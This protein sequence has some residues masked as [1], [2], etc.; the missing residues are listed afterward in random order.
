MIAYLDVIVADKAL[1]TLKRHRAALSQLS[2]EN[3]G[4]FPMDEAVVFEF[5]MKT[6]QYSSTPSRGVSAFK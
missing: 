4:F 6:S 2:D 1:N 5:L 3:L